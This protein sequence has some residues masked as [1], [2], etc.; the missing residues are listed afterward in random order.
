MA[1]V[2]SVMALWGSD[3]QI[4]ALGQVKGLEHLKKIKDPKQGMLLLTGHFTT[5]ELTSQLLGLHHPIAGM[6]RP[7]KNKLMDRIFLKSRMRRS[8]QML[9]RDELRNTARALRSGSSVLYAFDQN[10]GQNSIFVPFFGVPAATITSTARLAKLGK[11]LIVPFF[12]KRNIDGSYTVEIQ[13][14]LE[15]FPSGDED[16]DVRRLNEI[17]EQAIIKAPEQYLWIHR[18]FKTR[19]EGEPSVYNS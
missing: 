10:Y 16:T 12:P 13:A 1:V 7:M 19:P 17:L 15:N 3:E 6:Y 18:R 11:A 2:E 8:T 4:L 14:P 9:T 5:M